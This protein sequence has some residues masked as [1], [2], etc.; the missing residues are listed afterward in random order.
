MLWK[1]A[2]VV[3]GLA[4][5][6]ALLWTTANVRYQSCLLERGAAIRLTG[7]GD[8]GFGSGPVGSSGPYGSDPL[9]QA[10]ELRGRARVSRAGCSRSPF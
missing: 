1:L 6:A 8:G 3:I 9:A 5:L 2:G 4:V 7:S 10:T